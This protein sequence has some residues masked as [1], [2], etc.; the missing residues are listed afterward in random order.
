MYCMDEV[1][2]TCTEILKLLFRHYYLKTKIVSETKTF[3][4]SQET[5]QQAWD[6]A[7]G[8]RIN[9]TM[10]Q[11]EN[12]LNSWENHQC[13]W[14]PAMEK[15]G[16]NASCCSLCSLPPS[17]LHTE[18]CQRT[19]LAGSCRFFRRGWNVFSVMKWKTNDPRWAYWPRKT[20]P[21]F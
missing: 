11:E 3:S 16:L 6:V 2:I 5:P 12:D 8:V 10:S 13:Q 18:T 21:C 14:A 7:S 17:S 1:Y 19:G 20:A 15:L 4:W 9:P